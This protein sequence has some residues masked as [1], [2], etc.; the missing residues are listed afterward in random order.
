[1]AGGDVAMWV[2]VWMGVLRQ[3]L[4][5]LVQRPSSPPE[6]LVMLERSLLAVGWLTLVR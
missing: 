3:P 1:M 5:R 6:R 2:V 4:F